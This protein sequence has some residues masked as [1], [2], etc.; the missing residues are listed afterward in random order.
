MRRFSW[1]GAVKA[2]PEI[3]SA[4]SPSGGFCGL[5]RPTGS[6]PGTASLTNWLPKP[7]WYWNVEARSALPAAFALASFL[8]LVLVSMGMSRERFDSYT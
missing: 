7:G 2:V 5:L 8:V 4:N 3:S 6:A 1:R